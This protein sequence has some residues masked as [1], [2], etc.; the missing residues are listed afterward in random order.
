[1]IESNIFY[2]QDPPP[3]YIKLNQRNGILGKKEKKGQL[4]MI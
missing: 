3:P 4:E 2:I 1:M